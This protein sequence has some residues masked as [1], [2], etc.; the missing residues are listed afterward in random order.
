MY[1]LTH[2]LTYLLI[3]V[4]NEWLDG[5]NTHIRYLK[6]LTEFPT[7]MAKYQVLTHSLTYLL[8]HLT[9]YSLKGGAE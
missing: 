4:Q 7:I 5:I 2:L 1:S 9:T 3:I 8:T 6:E